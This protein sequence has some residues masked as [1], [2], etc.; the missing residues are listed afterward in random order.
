M[1]NHTHKVCLHRLGEKHRDRLFSHYIRPMNCPMFLCCRK[2]DDFTKVLAVKAWALIR[3]LLE[4][5]TTAQR[6]KLSSGL[7]DQCSI[8]H[9]FLSRALHESSHIAFV[10]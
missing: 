9:I 4:G 7:V 6:A 3:E 5:E 10:I 1:D 2:L 8:W